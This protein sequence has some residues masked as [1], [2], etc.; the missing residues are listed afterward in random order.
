MM[1]ENPPSVLGQ[2]QG[3]RVRAL[4]V[5]TTRRSKALPQV[6][7][8]IEAGLAC[9]DVSAWFGVAAPAGLPPEIVARIGA[10]LAKVAA[11]PQTVSVMESRGADVAYVPADAA[12]AFMAADAAKWKQ[13]A[14][15]AGIQLS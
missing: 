5:T 4:A 10:V 11:D 8:L 7:T 2:I 12:A 14:T 1:F 9:F 13:V 3:G 6:S 15:F